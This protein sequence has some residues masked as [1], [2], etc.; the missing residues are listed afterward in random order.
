MEGL[1][2]RSLV[3]IVVVRPEEAVGQMLA[4]AEAIT[5]TQRLP[6]KLLRLMDRAECASRPEMLAARVQP[7]PWKLPSS[8]SQ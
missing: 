8:R 2:D 1:A 6:G 7:E 3:V 4:K 5:G